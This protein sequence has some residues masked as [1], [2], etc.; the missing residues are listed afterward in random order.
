MENLKLLSPRI[1]CVIAGKAEYLVTE[2][3]HFNILKKISFPRIAAIP[4][5][6][7]KEIVES[8]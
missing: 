4:I 8:L 6:R 2:D 5:D 7:F 1:F 3:Q